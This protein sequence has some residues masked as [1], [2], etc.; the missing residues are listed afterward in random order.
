MLNSLQLPKREVTFAALKKKYIINLF[1][2]QDSRTSKD[3][4]KI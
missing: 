1:V 3:E 4:S 2:E